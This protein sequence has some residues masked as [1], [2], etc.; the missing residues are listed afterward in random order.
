MPRGPAAVV[1]GSWPTGPD[2]RGL[3]H[4]HP[5]PD[6]D[7]G[8]ERQRGP[9]QAVR[10]SGTPWAAPA[11]CALAGPRSTYAAPT[12]MTAPATGPIRYTHQVDSSPMATSG[13]KLRAG[14]IDAP[15]NGPPIVP[16]AMM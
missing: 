15:S 12:A 5:R 11:S 7:P 13:P 10:F 3:W 2:R 1:R 9:G 4:T 16:Q 8:Q 6:P 14:F